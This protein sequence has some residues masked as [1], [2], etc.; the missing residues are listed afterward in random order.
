[1][2]LQLV[3][4][5]QPRPLLMK[6]LTL[7]WEQTLN[8][9]FFFCLRSSYPQFPPEGV[10][11][12]ILGV[13]L[14]LFGVLLCYLVTREEYRRPPNPEE[15]ALSVHFKTLTEGEAPATP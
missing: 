1:M 12:N 10:L 14:V 5:L 3:F 6:N 2:A 8:A 13:L 4:F 15:E 9:S 7:V 11:A